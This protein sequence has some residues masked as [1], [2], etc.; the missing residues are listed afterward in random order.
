[1]AVGARLLVP[2]YTFKTMYGITEC[3]VEAV[4]YDWVV[5]RDEQEADVVA[6]YRGNPDALIEFI[7]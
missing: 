5:V 3:R 6:F 1:M 2:E 4:G 7:V